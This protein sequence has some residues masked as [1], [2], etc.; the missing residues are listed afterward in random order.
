MSCAA[1]YSHPVKTSHYTDQTCCMV[2]MSKISSYYPYNSG[3]ASGGEGERIEVEEDKDS[4][5]EYEI[6]R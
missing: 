6:K 3:T 1:I 4:S 2:F 5:P